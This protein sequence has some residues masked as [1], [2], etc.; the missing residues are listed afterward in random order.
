M[1]IETSQI[2]KCVRLAAWLAVLYLPLHSNL[3]TAAAPTNLLTRPGFEAA[4]AAL[5]AVWRPLEPGG[6]EVDRQEKHTGN[7][8]IKLAIA[9]K[10]VTKGASYVLRS[11]QVK[12]PSSILVSAWSKGEGVTGTKD[13]AY[14][15]YIDVNYADGTNLHQ[16]TARLPKHSLAPCGRW[17]SRSARESF[18][19]TS[20]F[21][22]SAWA[23]TCRAGVISF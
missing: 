20:I 23:V 1:T 21:P 14:A 4:E 22:C 6:Y 9:R 5:K 18:W 15:I 2:G 19:G 17:R 16:V 12:A 11:D 3:A 7:Q 10:G 8:S 13:D